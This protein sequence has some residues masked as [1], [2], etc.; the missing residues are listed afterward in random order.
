MFRTLLQIKETQRANPIIRNIN[1]DTEGVARSLVP[2][3][4]LPPI[5]ISSVLEVDTKR[6]AQQ[7]KCPQWAQFAV[8]MRPNPAPVG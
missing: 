2:S 4:A 3:V 1:Y 7:Q 5:M 8:A 6:H